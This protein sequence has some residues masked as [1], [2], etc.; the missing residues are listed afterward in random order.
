MYQIRI[1]TDKKYAYWIE[2][3]LDALGDGIREKG[4]VFAEHTDGNRRSVCFASEQ[5]NKNEVRSYIRNAIIELFTALEKRMYFINALNIRFCDPISRDM[6]VN[7]LSSFNVASERKYVSDNLR[8]SGDF[9]LDG[10]Y[11]FILRDLRGEWRESAGLILDN[12]DLVREEESFNVILK[13]LLSGIEARSK[14]ISVNKSGSA[15]VVCCD[16][17]KTSVNYYSAEQMLLSLIDIAPEKVVIKS[18]VTDA[19]LRKKLREIFCVREE[20]IEKI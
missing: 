8:L 6:L 7:T 11:N 16:A 9:N 4:G 5:A 3:L 18:S 19:R 17:E 15:Y 12:A 10:F 20:I 14:V 2:F 1:S 13:F